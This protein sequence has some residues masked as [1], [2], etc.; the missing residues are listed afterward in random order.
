[1][2][3]RASGNVARIDSGVRP[4]PVRAEL[5]CSQRCSNRCCS[6]R[7]TRPSPKR[8][9][10]KGARSQPKVL[11]ELLWDGELTLLTDL[12]SCQIFESCLSVR[13]QS[14]QVGISYHACI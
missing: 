3:F 11:A 12:R 5:T 7:R 6:G 1:M 13:H 4:A 14:L 2:R 9:T 8:N 10:A